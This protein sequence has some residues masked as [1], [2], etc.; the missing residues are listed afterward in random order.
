VNAEK[1][2]VV[3]PVILYDV[4]CIRKHMSREDSYHHDFVPRRKELEGAY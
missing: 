1:K 2:L 3:V 4:N